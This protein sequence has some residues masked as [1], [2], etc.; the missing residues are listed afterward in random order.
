M[1]FQQ[2]DELAQEALDLVLEINRIL[3][4]LKPNSPT[5]PHIKMPFKT[6]SPGKLLGTNHTRKK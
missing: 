6:V 1:S 2:L 4:D 3:H 5:L